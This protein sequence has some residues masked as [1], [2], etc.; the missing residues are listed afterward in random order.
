MEKGPSTFGEYWTSEYE[1]VKHFNIHGKQMGYEKLFDYSKAAYEF[2]NRK[3]E[4]SISF[5]AN[6]QKNYSLYKYDKEANEFIIISRTGKIVTYYPP[7][8]GFEYFYRQFEKWG[9]H[10]N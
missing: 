1:E 2:A 3:D 6:E 10:W 7:R 4:N 5:I 9:D 8:G